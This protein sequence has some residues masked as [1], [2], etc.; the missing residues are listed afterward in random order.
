M[1]SMY[2][3]HIELPTTS[4]T[5][6]R[7][8]PDG[9][10]PPITTPGHWQAD[11]RPMTVQWSRYL[12][13]LQKHD[14]ILVNNHR[15]SLKIVQRNA[16]PERLPLYTV[17]THQRP[18]IDN[19]LGHRTLSSADSY[20][21]L[22]FRHVHPFRPTLTQLQRACFRKVFLVDVKPQTPPP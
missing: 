15:K 12:R 11:V 16:T 6:F 9:E 13:W 21:E 8:F 20:R 4:C 22:T 1:V 18:Q 10:N 19:P 5:N 17:V 2:H 3:V 14:I 7:V